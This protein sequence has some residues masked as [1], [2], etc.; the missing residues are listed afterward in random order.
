MA[1]NTDPW[2]YSIT[3]FSFLVKFAKDDEGDGFD[4]F[5]DEE[6]NFQEVSG[7]S[8]SLGVEEIKEG[9]ENMLMHRIPTRARYQNLVLKRGL[10]KYKKGKLMEWLQDTLMSF[11]F[12]PKGLTIS[13]IDENQNP[14]ATWVVIN[15]YPVAMKVSDFK[16]TESAVVVE[17]IELA[18]DYFKRVN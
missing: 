2:K 9:G 4:G 18:F 6:C 13:L 8:V 7:L 1:E 5:S 17:T 11:S 16:S 15:A 3:G 12:T 10:F 14:M